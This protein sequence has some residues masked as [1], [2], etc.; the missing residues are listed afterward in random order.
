MRILIGLVL[1]VGLAFSAADSLNCRL[2]GHVPNRV[3]HYGDQQIAAQGNLVFLTNRAGGLDI[4][5]VSDP[6]NPVIVGN[7][8]TGGSIDAVTVDGN[9]AYAGGTGYLRVVDISD[10]S[11]PHTVGTCA[12]SGSALSL[13]KVGNY[14]YNCNYIGTKG[15]S[16]VDVSDPAHPVTVGECEAYGAR[17]SVVIGDY[18]FVS[19]AATDSGHLRVVDISDP[20]NPTVVGNVNLYL[21]E[22]VC[23][24]DTNHIFVADGT[25]LRMFDVSN[26]TTPIQVGTYDIEGYCQGMYVKDSFAYATGGNDAVALYVFSISVPTTPTLVGY[27]KFSDASVMSVCKSIGFAYVAD[28]DSGL[29]VIQYDGDTTQAGDSTVR[30]GPPLPLVQIIGPILPGW[31]A[32]DQFS[33]TFYVAKTGSDL[34]PGTFAEPKLTIQAGVNLAY[35]G[36][37]VMVGAGTYHEEVTFPRSATADSAI[38]LRGQDTLTIIDNTDSVGATWVVAPEIGSGVYKRLG[39]NPN[40]MLWNGNQILKICQ[41]YMAGDSD[42]YCDKGFN[43]LNYATDKI[44]HPYTAICSTAFWPDVQALYGVLNSDTCYF[45]ERDGTDPNTLNLRAATGS[46]VGITFTGRDYITVEHLRVQGSD[47]GIVATTGDYNTIQDCDVRNGDYR[48]S[49][50]GNHNLITQNTFELGYDTCGK[51]GEWGD[52]SNPTSN[53]RTALY[54]LGKWLEGN[55]SSA[56]R[57][58]SV[59][60]TANE[61]SHNTIERGSIGVYHSS[62]DSLDVHGNNISQFSSVGFYLGTDVKHM[63]IYDNS[64]DHC[65]GGIR[66]GSIGDAADTARSGHIFNNTAYNDSGTGQFFIMNV[67]GTNFASPPDFWIYHNS[68]AGGAA[69]GQALAGPCGQMKVVNNIMSGKNLMASATALDDTSSTDFAAFDYNFLGGSFAN[70]SHRFYNWA[71]VDTMNQWPTDTVNGSAIHQVWSLGS[72]PDWIVPGASTAYQAGLNLSDSFSIRGVNYGPLLGMTSEY[73]HGGTTP[74]L[75]AEQ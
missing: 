70:N 40:L 61:L 57:G 24:V 74:N 72:E 50:G 45:R 44:W 19:T 67:Q 73:Y 20:T 64:I 39:Y 11:N 42:E 46:P 34:N 15:F 16:I 68:Y 25:W 29:W 13:N 36:D 26:P 47:I 4:L 66:F 75:G 7:L 8:P 6:A 10:S 55:S 33:D 31:I 2:T 63:S 12:V 58:V 17:Y 48:I 22:V 38:V 53:R 3:Y 43:V 5:G 62:G 71:A 65:N 14:V 35:A 28:Y 30:H 21:G 27:Y 1:L 41:N 60:G 51:F 37:L 69:W 56:D 49:I 52:Y 23:K 54:A 59:G 32:P 18:A 9:Y